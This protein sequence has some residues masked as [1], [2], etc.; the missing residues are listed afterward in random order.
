MDTFLF[1]RNKI[2]QFKQSGQQ[3]GIGELFNAG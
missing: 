1:L 3:G 2:E